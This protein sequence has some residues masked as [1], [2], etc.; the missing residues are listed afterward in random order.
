MAEHEKPAAPGLE[1]RSGMVAVVVLRGSASASRMLL[2]QRAGIR[3]HGA[4]T[5]IAGHVEPGE[6]GWQAARRELHEETGLTPLDFHATSF[7][8]QF[9]DARS[10]CVQVVPA[11]VARIAADAE[12][13]LNREHSAFRWAS[14]EDAAGMLPF[15]SQRELIAH[16]EREFIQRAPSPF[17]RITTG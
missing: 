16:V 6:A 5:Y 8:E 2:V 7:C 12:V 3:M 9:Y 1:I 13:R 11:F 14:F 15:G 17:L 4:W 10:D